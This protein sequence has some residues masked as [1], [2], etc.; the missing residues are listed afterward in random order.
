MTFDTRATKNGITIAEY[1]IPAPATIRAQRYE[2]VA[3][4]GRKNLSPLISRNGIYKTKPK[5]TF[6]RLSAHLEET[7]QILKTVP[8]KKAD[9]KITKSCRVR[10]SSKQKAKR[11]AN[12]IFKI[13]AK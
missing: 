13:R 9:A 8:K 3:T 11:N 2:N 5:A 1:A 12:L 4:V 7:Y 6:K 10:P